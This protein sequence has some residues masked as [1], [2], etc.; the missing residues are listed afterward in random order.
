MKK[1]NPWLI[2]ALAAAAFLA[3]VLPPEAFSCHGQMNWRFLPNEQAK[4]AL[5][6]L[7]AAQKA[8]PPVMPLFSIPELDQ[9]IKYYSNP[10]FKVGPPGSWEEFAVDCFMIMFHENKYW[11]WYVGTP[12]GAK[13][14]IGLAW[15]PDGIN[16]T[17]CTDNP[18]VRVGAAG[19]WDESI[20]LCQ[21]VLWD[22]AERQFKMWYVGGNLAG[23]FGIGY[24]TSPDGIN[25]AKYA[26]NPVMIAT[27]GW[28][29]DLL[30]GHTVLKT[31]GGYSM[32]YGGLDLKSDV[33][34]IG[35][36][37]STDGIH[38]TKH[39]NNPIL[40]PAADTAAWDGYSADT[41]DVVVVDDV[42]QMYYRGWRKR[43]GT[44]WIGR[45][46]SR[47]GVNWEKDALNPVLLT[48][49]LPTDWDNYQLYRARFV[50]GERRV[51]ARG[52]IQ[53]TLDRMYFTGRA[54]TLKAEVGLAFRPLATTIDGLP[55]ASGKQ[56]RIPMV[57]QDNMALSIE[58]AGNGK[59]SIV[60]FTP[61]LQQVKVS[62]FDQSG[63]RVRVVSNEARLP[64][65]YEAVWDGRNAAGRPVPAGLYYCEVAAEKY[66]L[67]K[68]IAVAGRR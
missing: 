38:W 7:I 45:A 24:A 43:G 11:L 51:S 33:S 34:Y 3:A 32:W 28:E 8:K 18:V 44:S 62:I 14:Q 42:Y 39:P 53:V 50:P 1:I 20:L 19:A 17:R 25:W 67:T 68:E 40:S 10:I 22:E 16:W 49:S 48:S 26:G 37:T 35:L 66:V 57:N 6:K 54:Y 23:K 15:S 36:A 55:P 59:S 31:P 58:P 46:T 64:G 29:G 63:R 47:D 12:V 52:S 21:H 61:W 2:A 4:A 65:T 60:Y 30:E 5:A 27:D 41:P 13:C 9:W 56:P